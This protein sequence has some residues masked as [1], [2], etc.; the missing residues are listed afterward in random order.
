[1][2]TCYLSAKA[3]LKPVNGKGGPNAGQPIPIGCHSSRP[4]CRSCDWMIVE[5]GGFILHL[6]Y[7]IKLKRQGR[8]PFLG[9]ESDSLLNKKNRA[10]FVFVLN[11]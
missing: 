11:V 1:M 2:T 6:P 7:V 9:R 4:A 5:V 3:V 8:V 10:T